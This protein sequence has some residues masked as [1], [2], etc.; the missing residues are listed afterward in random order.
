MATKKEL[1]DR[2]HN[3]ENALKDFT[4]IPGSIHYHSAD[5]NSDICLDYY[6]FVYWYRKVVTVLP[7]FNLGKFK[8]CI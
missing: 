7:E 5:G 6:E 1:E 8:M 3:L 2:I 4:L